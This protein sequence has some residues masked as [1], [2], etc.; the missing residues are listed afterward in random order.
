VCAESYYRKAIDLDLGTGEETMDEEGSAPSKQARYSQAVK[1][2]HK[3]A[4]LGTYYMRVSRLESTTMLDLAL[5]HT[6]SASTN[7]T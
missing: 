6:P 1:Y 3:A 2:Y 4:S 7:V 5:T